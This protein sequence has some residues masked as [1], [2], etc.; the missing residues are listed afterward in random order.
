M[1]VSVICSYHIPSFGLF[2]QLKDECAYLLVSKLPI[3]PQIHLKM[4]R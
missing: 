2:L 3:Q 4:C 1:L